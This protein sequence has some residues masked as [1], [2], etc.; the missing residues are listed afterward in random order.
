MVS[1]LFLSGL[2]VGYL[3]LLFGIAF[4]GERRSIYPSRERLRPYIYSLALGVYCTTWTF[5]GA[6]GTAVRDGWS[7]L[8]IYL[9]PA[10]VFLAATPFLG[11][12]VAIARAHNIT[13]IGDF[14]S[15]RFGKSP[16]LAALVT[17]IALT[18][19]V[20]YLSLQYKA[21]GTSI[22]VLTGSVDRHEAW[23]T[24]PALAVALLMALFAALFGTR[25]LDAT[26]HHEG[27]MLAIAFES[28]VKLLSFVAVGVFALLHLDGA[29]PLSATRLGDL[30]DVASPSFAASTLLAAV[31]IFCLPRQF[32][33]GVVE[34]ADPRDLR[35]AR[36]V[37]PAYL[38]VFTVFVVPVVLAG[39]GLGL[40]ERHQ[41]DSFV[42]S[43]PMEHGATSLAILVFLGGLSAA[44]AMVIMASIALAT[45]I[46]NDLV[47]PALWR[48]RWLGIGPPA[49]VGR[50]V[51]RTRR[52]V[53]LLL[54]LLAFAYHRGTNAPASLASIGLLAF[55]AVANFAPAILAGLYW[56]GA[57][58]EGVF[59]GLVGRLPG[60]DLRVAAAD[61]RRRRRH[62]PAAAR[63]RGPRRGNEHADAG[64]RVATS[65]ACRFVTA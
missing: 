16:A 29:P 50:L 37:F 47:M 54:A 45:M 33:V 8:P 6:V 32:L 34:C 13:S 25:Q 11:R 65:R 38:A 7:Y 55:A 2:A 12:L 4:Y 1:G 36:W 30:R 27:V 23:F 43:L 60:V 19:A 44:T 51:L 56:R 22:D 63:R 59:A 5:F 10:L 64:R 53:I 58:R 39:L 61:L 46:T 41:A 26:E 14:I 24:D 42:L 49:D 57:T 35:T 20:P 52:V 48:G 17:V 9:G 31:A 40:G 62:R 21:V 15:S 18:A 3:A 28:L